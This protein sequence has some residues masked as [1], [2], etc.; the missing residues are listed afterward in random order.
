MGAR[1]GDP[2]GRPSRPMCPD[3]G[4]PVAVCWCPYAQFVATAHRIVVLQHP[5][6]Q[7]RALGSVRILRRVLANVVVCVGVEFSDDPDVAAALADDDR[8]AVFLY[9]RAG[10]A[11]FDLRAAR[12]PLTMFVV[13]GTWTQARS[14]RAANPWLE[15]LPYARL[16]PAT[17]SVYGVCAQPGAESLC[18]LEAVAHALAIAEDND[19]VRRVL[20]R[21]LRALAKF[22]LLSITESRH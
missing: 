12:R 5:R 11:P 1:P 18:T 7:R 3:C 9:P 15:D 13:D 8:D 17:P 4:R 16:S 20:V 2:I 6:E 10:L 22:H 14:L 21:P 19:A